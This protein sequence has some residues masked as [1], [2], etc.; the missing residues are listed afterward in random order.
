MKIKTFLINS[1]FFIVLYV[2]F[3]LIFSNFIFSRSVDHKCFIHV[4][5]GKFYKLRKNCFAKMRIIST[6]DPYIVYT[7]EKIQR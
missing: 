4:N 2:I 5:E 7:N 6:I 1:I 3:D